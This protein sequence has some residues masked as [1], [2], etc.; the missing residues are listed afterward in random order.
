MKSLIRFSIL[1]G[2][3][4]VGVLCVYAYFE[5]AN[6]N[7]ALL[8][9]A[10]RN[11]VVITPLI[12]TWNVAT[13]GAIAITRDEYGYKA[14]GMKLSQNGTHLESVSED[15]P[16]V[17]NLYKYNPTTDTVTHT[18]RIGSTMSDTRVLTRIGTFNVAARNT[19]IDD[20]VKATKTLTFG[21]QDLTRTC[22]DIGLFTEE[23]GVAYFGPIAVPKTFTKGVF[24]EIALCAP[25][26]ADAY[27]PIKFEIMYQKI[28]FSTK[29]LE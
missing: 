19:A 20:R 3:F 8:R 25:Y 18:I 21:L 23:K 16:A 10:V 26:V 13:G 7:H 6:L 27:K 22:I 11:A 5:W 29:Y 2:F 12:G 28:A 4:L 14:D 9:G 24:P 15:S 17:Y 1:T